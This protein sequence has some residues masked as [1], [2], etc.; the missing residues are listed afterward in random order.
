MIKLFATDLDGTLL[1]PNNVI[2][3]EDIEAIHRLKEHGIDFA[4]ATGRMERD[5]VKICTEINHDAHRI[6]QNGAFVDTKDNQKILTKT[7]DAATSSALHQ[8]VDTFPNP[9]CITTAD[10]SYISFK[11]PEIKALEE[12]LYF[13]LVEGVDFANDYNE[14]FLPSKYMLLGEEKD[15]VS[16]QKKID[17]TFHEVCESYLSDPHCVDIVPKGVS[18]AL[19]LT[20]LADYLDIKPE[21]I[22]VI[23]DSY[24]DIP[25]FGMSA[26]SFAMSTAP[27]AVKQ[28]ATHVVDD[29]FEAIELIQGK[30]STS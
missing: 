5:I 18:K 7:F 8:A 12:I 21:E 30:V 4:V 10:E 22:A 19:G 24:N 16:F 20:T 17:E 1:K 23:G 13:P 28:K 9:F 15:I 26:N 29:V 25:M 6:S 3:Q 27:E 14:A 2:K 11:T